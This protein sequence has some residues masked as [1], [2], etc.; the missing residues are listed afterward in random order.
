MKMRVETNRSHSRSKA[1]FTLAEVMIAS[2]TFAVACLA[3]FAGVVQGFQLVQSTR[4]N[5][6]ATQILQDNMEILRLYTWDQLNTPGFVPLSFTNTFNP[7]GVA[8]GN[9]GVTYYGTVTPAP[10]PLTESYATNIVVF[11][12]QLNWTNSN[13][14]THQRQ[15][16]TLVSRYGI[17]NYLY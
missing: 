7:A 6:R 10:A 5:L 17:H 3:G 14:L 8:S 1:A 16:T 9:A 12:F 2:G 4:E 15:I 11:T 13:R